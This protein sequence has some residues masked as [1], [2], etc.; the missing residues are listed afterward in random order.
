MRKLLLFSLLLFISCISFSQNTRIDK[1]KVYL[2]CTR[3]WLCDFD[4]VRSEMLMVDFVRDRFNADV[5]VLVNMQSSSS[6]GTQSQMNF[7]GL[8][9]FSSLTDTLTFYN[10]PT[11]TEDEQRKKLVHHLKLGLT[12]Y[13]AKTK[14]GEQLSISFTGTNTTK[15]SSVTIKKDPWNYWVFQL[16]TSGSLNGNANYKN[17]SAYGSFSADRETENWKIN[18]Y[19]SL[20]KNVEIYKQDSLESKFE[21]KSYDGNLQVA[22]SINQHWSYGLSASYENSLFSNYRAAYKLQP[23]IEYSFFPYTTFNSQRIVLQYMIG[24][25]YY[26]YYDTTVYFKDKEWQIQQSV[27]M[28]TSFTKPWGSINVGISYANY[29]DDFSKN[30]LSFN[31]A[32][33]WKIVKGLNFALWG[34][35]GLIHDQ[36]NIRKG[37]ASRDEILLRNREL[38]SS[39]EY[40]LGVGFSYRFGSILNNIV[41]PR[42]RGLSYSINL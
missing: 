22:K 40:N 10:D 23:K 36:I 29:F 30:N 35:Y 17:R 11:S 9:T 25:A 6:G 8:K 37:R 2:D 4:Y 3:G 34:N 27:R 32:V 21:R 41:N 42:F 26:N 20:S 18:G 16:S 15:D 39:F 5:H 12:R 14:A 33:S 24:P 1:L 38:E 7:I 19:L 13:I 28:I 31:G